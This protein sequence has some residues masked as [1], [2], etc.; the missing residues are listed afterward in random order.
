VP[1]ALTV[2][3]FIFFDDENQ[4]DASFDRLIAALETDI[5]WVRQHTEFGEAARKWTLAGR[6]GGLLLRP[7]ALEEAEHWIASRPQGAPA[8][9]EETQA[10]VG[11]AARRRRG[12]A[13]F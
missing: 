7:P 6:P 11:E 5:G 9:T 3:N 13:T 4:F 10:F 8:P 12:G 2:L 1:K